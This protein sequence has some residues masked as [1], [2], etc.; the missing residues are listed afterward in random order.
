[1]RKAIA[2]LAGIAV[3][4]AVDYGIAARE[5]VVTQG[6]VLLLELTPVDP[7]SLMQGD[8]MAL[9]FVVARGVSRSAAADGRIV[10]AVDNDGVARFRRLDDGAPLAPGEARLRYRIRNGDVKLATNAFFFEEGRGGDYQGARYG[11]FRVADDGD[12]VLT[13]LRD[14]NRALLGR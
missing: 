10:L 2:I 3:L 13:G 1:M 7:R 12:A 11:E 4:A 9:R 14:V 8:Y 6:R 5:R